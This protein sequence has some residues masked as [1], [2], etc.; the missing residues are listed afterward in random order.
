MI[1]VHGKSNCSSCESLKKWLSSRNVNFLYKDL[2]VD[3]ESLEK[4]QRLGLRNL[5]IVTVIDEKGNETNAFSGFNIKK[6]MELI[7]SPQV[8]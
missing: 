7:Q 5:P 6:I 3:T 1:I 4:F 2:E 8:A